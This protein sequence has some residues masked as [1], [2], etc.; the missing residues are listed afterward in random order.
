MI[1]DELMDHGPI[2]ANSKWQIASGETT[3]TLTIKLAKISSDLLI[4]T[5]PE[6]INQQIKPITQNHDQAIFTKII[7]KNNGHIDWNKSAAEIERSIRAYQPWPIAYSMIK[8]TNEKI[9][10]K[11]IKILKVNILNEKSDLP[12]GTIIMTNKKIAVAAS[13]SLIELIDVQ[14]EGKKIMTIKDL[15]NGHPEIIGSLLF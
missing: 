1:M 13:H 7:D 11:K 12:L 15:Y 14:L 8:S 5:I 3:G 6:W 2:L 10:Q 4:K 9:N